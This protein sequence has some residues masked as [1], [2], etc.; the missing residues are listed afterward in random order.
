[1][2]TKLYIALLIGVINFHNSSAQKVIQFK[3]SRTV[4]D[5]YILTEYDNNV[6]LKS[7]SEH[8]NFFGY[9]ARNLT[10][11]SVRLVH[12]LEFNYYGRQIAIIKYIP[13][14]KEGAAHE[15]HAIKLQKEGSRWKAIPNGFDQI[16]YVIKHIKTDALMSLY[17]GAKTEDQRLNSL[18]GQVKGDGR[19]LKFSALYQ[20][21]KHSKEDIQSM[22]DFDN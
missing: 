9:I 8:N 6:L 21:M 15:V 14:K 12:S 22:C 17:I 2:K 11:D 10:Q 1:M 19:T 13:N 7:L 20:I 4:L 5:R 3:G 16:E 18:K